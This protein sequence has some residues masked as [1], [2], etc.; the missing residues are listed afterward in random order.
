MTP[1]IEENARFYSIHGMCRGEAMFF[2]AAKRTRIEQANQLQLAIGENEKLNA[3]TRLIQAELIETKRLLAELQVKYDR[4]R[5]LANTA[6]GFGDSL[7]TIHVSLSRLI[8]DIEQKGN[9]A[10]KTAAATLQN[11]DAM[12]NV[13]VYFDLLAKSTAVT[14]EM[15]DELAGRASQIGG[16]IKLI[17]EVADQ[18]NLLALNAAI[19]AARAGEQGR[20][21]AV[22]A[23]EVRKLAERTAGSASEITALV[24]TN[25]NSMLDTQK[26]VLSWTSDSQR[27]GN[28][29]KEISQL[30]DKLHQS[31]REMAQAMTV[32]KLRAFA[33][34]TKVEH[35]L[36]KHAA[37]EMFARNEPPG[38]ASGD[39][40]C[41]FGKWYYDGE[42]K[43][44]FSKLNAYR[45]VG[46]LHREFHELLSGLATVP[47][48]EP[49][50][51]ADAIASLDKAER[52]FMAGL[53]RLVSDATQ[54]GCVLP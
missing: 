34:I 13:M 2:S 51:I 10:E 20:G 28:E 36:I 43:S 32:S 35:L 1:G 41:Q 37:I 23:D 31:S 15:I 52:N 17:R 12:L 25:R 7:K 9:S 50:V 47:L 11:R 6:T 46:Q 30:M 48:S 45:E 38:E 5:V 29:G 3:E 22:V 49:A 14:V 27:F 33:E 40:A 24:T 54:N 21:F 42:G 26:H 4:E 8:D 19:E 39:H 16:I 53:D 18:T 44:C